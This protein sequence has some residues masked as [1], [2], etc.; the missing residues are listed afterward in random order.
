MTDI[1]V[2]SLWEL[3]GKTW[4]VNGHEL[5]ADSVLCESLDGKVKDYWMTHYFKQNATPIDTPPKEY[6]V[7][8]YEDIVGKPWFCDEPNDSFSLTLK[9]ILTG[10]E[11]DGL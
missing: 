6:K 11:G 8:V 1:E 9:A 10:K 3:H 2:G 4:R 7:W 5:N